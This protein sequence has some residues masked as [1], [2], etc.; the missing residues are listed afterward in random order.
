LRL[1][2]SVRFSRV[3]TIKLFCEGKFSQSRKFSA[4][5]LCL[6]LLA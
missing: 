4:G 5:R 1:L 2:A 3:E 6:N